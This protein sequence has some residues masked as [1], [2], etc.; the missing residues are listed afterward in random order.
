MTDYV[1]GEYVIGVCL[2]GE[3]MVMLLNP[4]RLLTTSETK[5]L[6]RIGGEG[7]TP[8]EDGAGADLNL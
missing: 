7:F 3:E 2:V 1:G 5:E 6:G 8:M 4:D